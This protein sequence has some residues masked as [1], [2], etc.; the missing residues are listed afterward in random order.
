MSST[1]THSKTERESQR[2]NMCVLWCVCVC[3]VCVDTWLC[4]CW[5][6]CVLCVC[7]CVMCVWIHGC[8]CVC[9][10]VL[11]VCGYMCGASKHSNSRYLQLPTTHLEISQW[12]IGISQ[13][14]IFCVILLGRLIALVILNAASRDTQCG[15]PR[16]S[17]RH[18]K[19]SSERHKSNAPA[20]FAS[21]FEFTLSCKNNTKQ[22]QLFH[23]T[24]T[25]RIAVCQLHDVVCEFILHY[26]IDSVGIQKSG[27]VW[28]SRFLIHNSNRL[29]MG[30][31]SKIRVDPLNTN[32]CK[33]ALS[34][35]HLIYSHKLGWVQ[36]FFFSKFVL[37]R[38]PY[39]RLLYSGSTQGGKK[40]WWS[41]WTLADCEW[42]ATAQSP[43]ACRA[44]QKKSPVATKQSIL[45]CANCP[46]PPCCM[47]IQQSIQT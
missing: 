17:M 15:I 37:R 6:V 10:C 27:W 33:F 3:Y 5:C 38:K 24:I 25:K 1:S 11:C 9:V 2:L 30:S 35:F 29:V 40:E 18:P 21:I 12:L 36:Q 19:D 20:H 46:R 4:V 47:Y 42:R 31:F 41:V 39:S 22:N 13:W 43:S 34:R 26:K 32:V 23:N 7:V 45:P 28:S 8:V 44:P 14:I 16:Y